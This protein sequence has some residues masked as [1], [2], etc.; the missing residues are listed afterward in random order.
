MYQEEEINLCNPKAGYGRSRYVSI[1]KFYCH[2]CGNENISLSC[3]SSDGEYGD[4]CLCIK[5]LKE[6]M[7]KMEKMKN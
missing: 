6:I 5:C 2:K 1:G 7:E 3:D 4:V